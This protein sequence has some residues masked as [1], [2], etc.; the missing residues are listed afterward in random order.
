MKELVR[1]FETN[2]V[3]IINRGS[4]LLF[5]ALDCAG[6]LGYKDVKDVISKKIDSENI[7]FIGSRGGV[8]PPLEKPSNG[9]QSSNFGANYLNEAGLY[10]LIF[11]SKLESAARFKRWVFKE[12]LPSIRKTGSYSIIKD[13][14]WLQARQDGKVVRREETDTIKLFVEYATKQGSTKASMYY[15]AITKGVYSALYVLEK[16][17]N[18]KAI[19]ETLGTTDLQVLSTCE[20]VAQKY[21]KEG[22]DLEMHYKDIYRYAIAKVEEMA[23]IIGKKETLLTVVKNKELL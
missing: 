21:I 14:A 10:E 23:R 1:I 3:R 13:R 6:A 4:E 8:L 2:Q 22:M 20:H 19:R 17:A 9:G 15:M 18:W 5:H 7:I 12:V 11:T 16:G